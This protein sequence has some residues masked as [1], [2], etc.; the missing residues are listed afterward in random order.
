MFHVKHLFCR[1]IAEQSDGAS[2][3]AP[4]WCATAVVGLAVGGR[5]RVRLAP[6]EAAAA[7]R[8][9]GRFLVARRGGGRLLG[10][11]GDLL[12]GLRRHRAAFCGAEQA[13]QHVAVDRLE[14]DQRLRQLLE[15]GAVLAEHLAAALMRLL[16]DAA[17]LFVDLLG[18]A[19]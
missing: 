1:G 15:L 4:C 17:H 12:A 13:R 14:F 7:V 16:D 6:R 8:L 3:E 10:R 18:G 19:L 9:L 5:A 2:W 11:R